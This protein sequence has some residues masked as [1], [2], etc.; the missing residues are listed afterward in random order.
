MAKTSPVHSDQKQMARKQMH[1]LTTEP[2]NYGPQ[3]GRTAL[4]LSFKA[5]AWL[6]YTTITKPRPLREPHVDHQ[7][8][9]M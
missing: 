1:T 4:W 5:T 6:I 2:S 8:T 9:W 3:E 7:W